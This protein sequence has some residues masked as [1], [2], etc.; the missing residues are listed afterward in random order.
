MTTQKITSILNKAGFKAFRRYS[1]KIDGVYSIIR[2]G[3]FN[4][5]KSFGCIGVETFGVNTQKQLEALINAGVQAEETKT[6]SGMI[7]IV[8]Q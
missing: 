1:K 2:E 5:F 3:D 6:G 4:C 8:I 7:K